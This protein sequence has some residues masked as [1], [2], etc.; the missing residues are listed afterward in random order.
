MAVFFLGGWGLPLSLKEVVYI[1]CVLNVGEAW[2]WVGEMGL[3]CPGQRWQWLVR[4]MCDVTLAGG[5]F[6]EMPIRMHNQ[7]CLNS[8]GILETLLNSNHTNYNVR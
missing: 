4:W 6:M 2:R 7:Q 5:R 1:C 3:H 8:E